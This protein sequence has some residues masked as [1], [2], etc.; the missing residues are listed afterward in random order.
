MS[1]LMVFRIALKALGRNKMRTALTMLGMIIGVGAVITM[2]ALGTGAQ[3][4]IEEQIRATGT[5]TITVMSGNFTQGAVRMGEG[6]SSRL[7]AADAE[8]LRS[9]PGVQWVAEGASTRQTLVAGNQNWQASIQG[10]NVDWPLIRAWPLKYGLFFTEQDV[11]AAAKVIVLGSNVA[12][13]LYGAEVDPTGQNVR[14]RNHVFRIVGVFAS[15]GASSGGQNQDDQAFVPYT[16]VQKKIQGIQHLNNITVS[17]VSGDQIAATT[18]AVKASMRVTQRLAPGEEDT[19]RVFTQDDIIGF[20]T[21]QS[22]TMTDLLAGIAAVSLMVGGIGIMNIM[23]VSVTERTR[24]IGLRMAIG[25]RGRDVL[26]QF[27]V[28]AIVISLV[29]GGLGIAMGFGLAETVKWLNGWPAVIPMDSVVMA[30]GFAAF[31]G[32]F[33]GFYPA[34]KASGLD[35]IEALRFE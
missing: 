15:K 10:T 5:N 22:S 20:A 35:P 26:M 18:E 6:S 2:V 16:T 3:N 12:E 28:E 34:R 30:V 31:V 1:V 4:A 29:G 21:S 23:L 14:V 7:M 13:M 32:I 19:F 33:F 11:Q 27:L 17:A 8:A 9:V 24:E 25:A